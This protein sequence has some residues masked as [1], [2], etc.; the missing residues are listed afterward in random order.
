M[1]TSW[2]LINAQARLVSLP[3]VYLRL[4]A[5]LDDDDYCLGDVADVVAA[6][7]AMTTRLLRLVN[8]AY[9]GI[10]TKVDT[11]SRAVSLIGTQEV[12]D[13]VL[14]SSVAQGFAGQTNQVMEM[15]RFWKRSVMC[16]IVAR[17]LASQCNILDSERLFVAGLL[18]DLGHLFI[19]Q[20]LPAQAAEAM[21]LAAASQI[22]LYQVERSVMGLDY[23]DVGARLLRQWELPQTLWEP[24]G[25]HVE[26]EKSEEYSLATSLV[27]I[28]GWL[29]ETLEEGGTV[30]NALSRVS[31]NAWQETGLE[32]QVCEE[33]P[34][35]IEA[36]L[37]NVL[38]MIKPRRHAA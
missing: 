30:A 16:A 35:L 27:H 15:S 33:L 36:E 20:A 38:L 28:S 19:Y 5:L 11:V 8:S 13:L 3:D 1:S 26:P 31:P 21:E 34:G 7:P 24:V 14:A 23:A 32:A 18:R 17:E 2:E 37:D 12:H 6:D 9:F 4:K 29:S 25:D 22:P 10:G